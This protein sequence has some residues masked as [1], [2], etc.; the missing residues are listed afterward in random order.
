MDCAPVG[1]QG[2][3]VQTTSILQEDPGYHAVAVARDDKGTHRDVRRDT[4]AVPIQDC[5]KRCVVRA[6]RSAID[7]INVQNKTGEKR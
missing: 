1:A 5:D 4:A 2:A 3:Q 6:I 7:G